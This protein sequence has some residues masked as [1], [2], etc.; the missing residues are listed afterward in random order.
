[1]ETMRVNKKREEILETLHK[2]GCRMTRQREVILD[3]IL[4]GECASVKEIYYQA[5]ARDKEIGAATVYRMLNL[6]EENGFLTRNYHYKIT[7]KNAQEAEEILELELKDGSC[8]RISEETGRR[9][10]ERGLR[11]EGCVEA[12]DI[13]RIR[14]FPKTEEG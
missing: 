10:L 4:T 14:R 2:I 13:V 9:A 11:Q 12:Q 3:V 8:L 5:A 1:M 7:E 6:L